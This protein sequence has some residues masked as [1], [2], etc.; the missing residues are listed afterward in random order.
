[1]FLVYARYKSHCKSDFGY[2]LLPGATKPCFGRIWVELECTKKC[3]A[4]ALGNDFYVNFSTK[5]W[6][7]FFN[8]WNHK[9]LWKYLW[10]RLFNVNIGSYPLFVIIYFQGYMS[11]WY[12]KFSFLLCQTENNISLQTALYI[13]QLSIP[14]VLHYMKSYFIFFIKHVKY[15]RYYQLQQ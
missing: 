2:I 10:S 7:Q 12:S 6:H 8:F 4:H 9:F 15:S 3:S 14:A 11:M 13:I 5:W 1:M